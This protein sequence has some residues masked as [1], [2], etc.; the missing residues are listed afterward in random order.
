MPEKHGRGIRMNY[1]DLDIKISYHSK[2]L[3]G[4][5]EKLLI[6][7]LKCTKLYRRGTG[8][9][10]SSVLSSIT[11]G[12]TELVENGGKIQMVASPKF[13]REDLDAINAGYRERDEVVS[14]V[15]SKEFEE[16]LDKMPDD[17]L[18]MLAK[19]VATGVLDIRIIVTD[20]EDG[21]GMY[22]DKLGILEDFDGNR[23]V[24]YGSPNSSHGGYKA[25][26]EKIRIAKSWVT[27]QAESVIDEEAEFDSL[28]NKYN[29]EVTVYDFKESIKKQIFV[30]VERKGLKDRLKDIIEKE[31]DDADPRTGIRLRKYQR[32]AIKAWV[33][34]GYK[35]FFV[36]ATGTGKTWTAI[37]AT[38]E[39]TDKEAILLVI[40]A[41]YKHL[42]KQ[43]SEDVKKV[44]PDNEII[45]VSS[46]NPRWQAELTNAVMSAK[47]TEKKTVIAISTIIS[48]N[49]PAF[50]RIAD[51]TNM[52]RMLIVDEAH[53]FT[54]R[55]PYIQYDY[56]YLLGLSATPSSRKNDKR[57]D[58]LME[59]FGGKVFDLP[60]E[61]AIQRGHLVHYNYHP[62]FV[63]STP[64]EEE[65]FQKI[66]RRMMACWHG[67]KCIDPEEFVKQKRNRLRVIA[68]AG[69]KMKQ[70]RYIMGNVKEKNHFIVY[71]GDGRMFNSQGEEKRHIEQVKDI[72]TEDKYRVSQF[73]AQENMKTRMELVESF[74]KGMIDCLVA[75]RCLDEGIN[76]PSINGALI[77]ASN[78]DYREFVQRRGRILRKYTDEYSGE[79]KKNA[80]IYDVIVL[81]GYDMVSWAAIELRR[82]Y[83]YARLADN[84]DELMERL[85]QMLGDYGLELD[86]IAETDDENERELDE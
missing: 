86:D 38:K 9:F 1:R 11:D 13:Q 47:Y 5:T 39:I 55:E 26:Y 50:K 62:I 21:D 28:W 43:W 41:P 12:V 31:E 40:C 18:V 36:M 17:D 42:V 74:N 82:F 27:G 53:R 10:S 83:E 51:K 84:A 37:Y 78:D 46:E 33:D 81:P 61:Y 25:N 22:H 14:E 69:E 65:A 6:P 63:D 30:V 15:F 45:L 7:A 58:E 34:N 75:I 4:I 80:N 20:T 54:N 35:G 48:F 68:M 44:Y 52:Q 49:L 66:T 70:F 56:K 76:I 60:I 72:L 16:E 29:E 19:L 67:D 57:G 77:L 73:T 23:V 32:Q 8:F 24:F 64:D 3:D 71:C 85:Y 79:E 2:G 59:F